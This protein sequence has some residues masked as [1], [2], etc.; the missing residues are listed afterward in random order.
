M[1]QVI[2]GKVQKVHLCPDC[3]KDQGVDIESPV[4]VT[5][6]LLG[7]GKESI[8]PSLNTTS[9]TCGTC[10]MSRAD[11][12]KTGRLGC[13]D[14]YH[15]FRKDLLQLIKAMHHSTQHV[16]RAPEKLGERMA[17]RKKM[18]DLETQLEAAIEEERFEEAA[19]IKLELSELRSSSGAEASS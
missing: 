17:L 9:T 2:E 6:V 10:L 5:D 16:G 14:C 4:S 11:F 18:A 1:T 8:E 19:K 7:L 13:S 15:I 3:A 12:K